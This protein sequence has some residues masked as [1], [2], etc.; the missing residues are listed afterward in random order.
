MKNGF[1]IPFNAEV[2]QIA[3]PQIT[4]SKAEKQDMLLEIYKLTELGAIVPC[5]PCEGQFISK[6]FLAPKPDGTK[7]FILNL[8]T[9]NKFIEPLHFKMEDYR[10]A[11]KLI[12]KNCYMASIDLK[13]AYLLLPISAHD[14]KYLRFEFEDN[15]AKI[16]TFEFTSMPYGLSVA[17]RTFT[18]LMKV[19]VTYLRSRGYTSV[20]YLDDILCIGRDYQECLKNINETIRLLEYLGFVIN[21]NK[22]NLDP[23]QSCKYLGF[24][25]N[26]LDMTISLPEEKRNNISRL[27]QKF[28]FL[29][30]CTIRDFA[31]LIG[32]LTAACPAIKYG[33]AYTKLLEREKFLALQKTEHYDAKFRPSKEILPDLDWWLKNISIAKNSIGSLNYDLEIFTDASL[34]G[35][36]A[37]CNQNRVN[38]NWK[39][40]EKSFHINYLELMAIFL[41]LK[42][43]AKDLYDCAIL[44][45][46]DNTTAISYINRMGGI[47]FPHLNNLAKAIWQWC[48]K[49]N[50]L[51]FAAYINTKENVEADEESRKV[52]PDIE[53]SLSD[54]TFHE[55]QQIFGQP[56]IDLF[57]SRTN[58]KCE[59]YVSWKQDPDSYVVDAFTINWSQWYFYAFPPF[60][61]ILKCLQKIIND[62]AEGI[63]VFPYWPSQPWF[64]LLTS[65]L[66]S[67]ITFLDPTKALPF[68]SF[69]TRHQFFKGNT[70]AVAKL[71]GSHS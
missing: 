71:S 40:C 35:W 17:P 38:G 45:R 36:G 8:K 49:R 63:F 19:V 58:T 53:W 9:L 65:L 7:R 30:T 48:E 13:E 51:L 39:E 24:V 31:H 55:I 68:S 29:R 12:T 10:T 2:H 16:S 22:S 50:I 26:S 62:K 70:L 21:Y 59:I 3:K 34:T 46:V 61:L 23:K 67:D 25:F 57:A 1:P 20:V 56:E 33:W 5:E 37:Y 4:L 11:S 47:K 52:N 43:F 64:P 32:T 44:L 14:R 54:N 41:S 42:C 6:T 69:R 60:P 18:K 15:D 27:L 28:H 66:R